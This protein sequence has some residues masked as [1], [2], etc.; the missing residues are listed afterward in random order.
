MIDPVFDVLF[1]LH[2]W[3]MGNGV[4]ELQLIA[5][6]AII[7]VFWASARRNKDL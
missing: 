4:Q 3:S 2:R 7:I 5:C 6:M 1:A